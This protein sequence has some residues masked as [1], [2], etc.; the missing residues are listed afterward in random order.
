MLVYV[1]D[2][3]TKE[4]LREEE[5]FIDPLETKK[6][7][8]KIYLLPANA[9]FEKPLDKEDGKAVVF[10]GLTWKLID[11][12]RGK[13]T[14]K[15]NQIEEIKTLEPVEK[16]L[17]D[18][19]IDGLNNGTLIIVDNDV[20]EKPAP[21]KEEV[22]ET[23]KQLY[24]KLVDP[25]TAQI[26][27]LRDEPVMTDEINAEIERL[28]AERSELVVRIKEENPYPAETTETAASNL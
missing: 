27:R 11:D 3:E 25:L 15:D 13:F 18:E 2:E 14:I 20:V 8:G 10:D 26:S 5:A 12:N 22:S 4:F 17:T 21:T 23:R 19:E 16:I 24:T 9:T 6:Q 28:K 1:Y 7:G